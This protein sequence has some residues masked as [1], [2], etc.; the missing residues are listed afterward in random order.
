M[1]TPGLFVSILKFYAV[2]SHEGQRQSRGLLNYT[3]LALASCALL[4]QING[5][6]RLNGDVTRFGRHS[7][8]D[9]YLDSLEL[10]YFIS[11]WHAEVHFVQAGRG[12][13][14]GQY[15][16]QDNSLNGTYINGV[17]VSQMMGPQICVVTKRDKC[18]AEEKERMPNGW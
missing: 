16:V 5:V 4:A 8:N 15:V 2:V 3:L 18:S 1:N 13:R 14:G 9:H 11:R 6:S 7:G 10:S 12:G 17:R